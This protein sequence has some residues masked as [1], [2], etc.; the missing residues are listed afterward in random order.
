MDSATPKKSTEEAVIASGPPSSASCSW[1]S[2]AT[3]A[4]TVM[5]SRKAATE[6]DSTVRARPPSMRRSSS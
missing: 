6:T 5:G 4:P 2:T 1:Q 3:P